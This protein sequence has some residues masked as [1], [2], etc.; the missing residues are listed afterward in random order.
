MLKRV[1][2]NAGGST[3]P[4]TPL[5]AYK[6]QRCLQGQAPWLTATQQ[7]IPE[8]GFLQFGGDC[9][10]GKGREIGFIGALSEIGLL[11]HSL[12]R[13]GIPIQTGR[14]RRDSV[15]LSLCRGKKTRAN[16]GLF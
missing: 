2:L 15:Y 14:L 7:E 8:T 16:P 13:C 3:A 10:N 12:T 11:S 1:A 4:A 6:L 5:P 9:R